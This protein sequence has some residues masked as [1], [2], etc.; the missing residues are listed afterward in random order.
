MKW[1]SLVRDLLVNP[2]L[3]VI[4]NLESISP[5]I[6]RPDLDEKRGRKSATG[7]ATTNMIG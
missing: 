4:T 1:S 3:H 7:T 6:S 5:I 2:F